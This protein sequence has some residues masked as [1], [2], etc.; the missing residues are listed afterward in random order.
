MAQT[1]KRKKWWEI[2]TTQD[3]LDLFNL[4]ARDPQY[5][6][7]NIE[8]VL[9]KLSWTPEKFLQVASPFLKRRI[10]VKKNSKKGFLIGYW[11]RVDD[12]NEKIAA[13]EQ[14]HDK[15]GTMFNPNAI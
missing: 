3:E 10:I 4:L 11:E 6:W 9:T 2:A 8:S 1:V 5:E 13:E 12:K 7:R 15:S 14:D